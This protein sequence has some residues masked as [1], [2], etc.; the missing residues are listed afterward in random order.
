MKTYSLY[1]TTIPVF[2]RTLTTLDG[3]LTK[4]EAHAARVKTPD[5]ILQ[6]RLVF[7]QFPLIRQIQIATDVAKRTAGLLAGVEIPKFEDTEKTFAEAHERIKKTLDFLNSVKEE[8]FEGKEDL[9]MPMAWMPTKGIKARENVLVY[10][11]PNF[12]FHVVTAYSIVRKNG[13]EIGKGDY[14]GALPLV[15]VAEN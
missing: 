14:M 13:V 1:E 3:L 15:D 6:D 9:M 10:I 11:L 7:D 12:F 2:I 4:T 5:V 8:Q